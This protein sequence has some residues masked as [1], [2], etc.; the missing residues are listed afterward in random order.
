[1]N[2]DEAKIFMTTTKR[3]IQKFKTDMMWLMLLSM[4]IVLLGFDWIGDNHFCQHT[5]L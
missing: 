4:F 1:M 5:T 3:E 2:N